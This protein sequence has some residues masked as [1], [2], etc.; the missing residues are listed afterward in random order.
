MI[1]INNNNLYK[2]YHKIKKMNLTF[3]YYLNPMNL[4]KLLK[5]HPI[6]YKMIFIKSKGNNI[7][8]KVDIKL[9]NMIKLKIFQTLC[10]SKII[11]DLT[12]RKTA[13]KN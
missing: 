1:I 5:N 12:Q 8:V 4:N 13:N 9:T 6:Y 3:K 11:K 7:E 10:L 2:N